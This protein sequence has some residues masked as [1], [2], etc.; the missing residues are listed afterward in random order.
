MYLTIEEQAY[1]HNYRMI[2]RRIIK[3]AK[4]KEN[5]RYIANA[6]NKTRAIWKII[7]K[8]LGSTPIRELGKEIRCGTQK[9][10]NLKGIAEMF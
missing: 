8:K 7:N 10:S 3:K 1:I 5:D 9:E 6:K 2:Y 4:R